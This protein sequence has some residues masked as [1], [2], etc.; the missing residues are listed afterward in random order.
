LNPRL[1]KE[2]SIVAQAKRDVLKKL[3]PYIAQKAAQDRV[4]ERRRADA[5]FEDEE[6]K[7]K[8]VD[9]DR[10]AQLAKPKPIV[11]NGNDA[12]STIRNASTS[13]A[14]PRGPCQ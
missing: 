10:I 13:N 11:K 7:K 1:N 14:F 9:L 6:P 8:K 2:D 5:S 4:N 3:Q 12:S